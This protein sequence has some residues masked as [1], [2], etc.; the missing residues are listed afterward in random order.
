MTSMLLAAATV[1]VIGRRFTAAAGWCAVAAMLS[2][3]GLMHGYE[4]LP[5]GTAILLR[6]AWEFVVGYGVMA[7]VFLAAR[8]VTRVEE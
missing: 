4:F 3:T 6:P 7:G 1:C 8:W 2:A 5:S